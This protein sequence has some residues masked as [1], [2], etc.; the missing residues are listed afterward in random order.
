MEAS[1][2]QDQ[3]ESSMSSVIAVIKSVIGQV[4]ALTPEG[5]QRLLIEGDRLFTG[6]QLTTGAAG[7]VSLQLADGRI[8]DLGR[9]TQWSAAGPETQASPQAAGSEVGGL[10]QAIAAGADPTAELAPTAAGAEATQAAGGGGSSHSFVILET[11][12]GRLE[13]TVGFTTQGFALATETTVESDS[14]DLAEP[15]SEALTGPAA[16]TNTGAVNSAPTFSA[17]ATGLTISAAEDTSFGGTFS[18]Q[19]PDGDSLTFS[20]LDSPSNGTLSLSPNGDWSY[21]PNPNYNGP[22]S[23]QIA[24]SDSRGGVTNLTLNLNLTPVNDAPVAEADSA[25]AVEGGAAIGGQILASDVDQPVGTALTFSTTSPVPGLTF[26]ADGSWSFDPSDAAYDSLAVGQQLVLEIPVSVTDDQGATGTTSLSITLTGSNDAPVAVAS[27]ASS[28]ENAALNASVAPASDIDGSIAAN[29]YALVSGVSQGSLSFNADGSYSFEPGS[30]FDD[31]A[32]GEFREVT[33]SYSATDND[34][35]VSAPAS[36][37]IRVTGSND[38][39]VATATS[40]AAV[41]DGSVLSGQLAAS[42]ADNGA[43]LSFSLNA[44]TPAGFSLDG[45][46][47]AWSFDPSDAAYQA[48]AEGEVQVIALPFTVT[49]EHGAT[50]QSSLTLTLTGSNDAPVASATTAAAVEDGAVISGQLAASDID[51]NATLTFNLIQ[52]APAGF[53]L[54]SATG[55]W[56]FDANDAVYQSLAAGEQLQISVPFTVT[57]EHGATSQSVLNLTVTGTNDAPSVAAALTAA[58]DE[59]DASFSLDLLAGAGDVDNGAVL[60]VSNVSSLPAGVTLLGSTLT[61]DPAHAAF[62]DLAEGEERLITVSYEVVDQH[63]AS[64]AQSISITITGTNDAPVA[65]ATSAAAAEDD[66]MLN[67]QLAASDVDSSLLTFSLNAAT[68]AGFSLDGATGAWSFD[69]SDAAYQALADGEVQV[70]ELPFTVTDEHGATSQSV[71]TLTL[72]GSND[73]PVASATTA[74]AVEDGILNPGPVV[75]ATDGSALVISIVTTDPNQ[76]FSFDWQFSTGDYLPFDDFA[77]IQI[78]GQPVSL[79]SSV[80]G[81]GSGGNSGQ[82]TL[83]HIFATPGTHQIVIGVSDAGDTSVNSALSISNL[84]MDLVTSAT[85]VGA[86]SNLGGTW[87]LT[88][89][90]ASNQ[91][92]TNLLSPDAVTGQLQASDIDHNATLTFS[93]IQTAPAGFSLDSSTGAWTFDPSDAAYQALAAGEIKVIELPFTVTDEHGATSQSVL[94]LTVTGTNDAPSVAAALTAA[95]DEDDASFNLDLLAGANDVDNSAVLGVTN[96]SSLPAGLTLLGSTLNVDPAHAAFQDLAAGEERLITVSYEVV[97]QHGASVAQSISITI[98]GTNDVPSVA[99]ALTAAANEDASS[100][101]LDLLAGAGDVDNGAVLGVSNLNGLVDGLSLSGSTLTVDPAHAAFQNL[102]AGEERLI[103]VTYEVVDQHGASVAQS[104]SITITGTNDAPVASLTSAAAAEDAALING[105]LAASDADTNAVLSFSLNAAAPA[106]FSLDGATG[107]WT[108]DPSDAAYQAL[109]EGEVQVIELPFTVTDEHGATSQSV[110]SLTVTGTNDAPSVAAALTAAADEDDA[111]FSL[112]LLAGANDVD[113]GST[114]GVA[115][116][117]SLPAGVSLLGSTLSVDPAHAAFQDL[118]AGEERQIVVSYE[119]VDGQGGSVA[120]TATIT[121]TGSNDAPSV[122]AALNAAANEDAVSFSLDLLAGANDVDNGAV[123]GVS[124]LYGLVDGLSLSGST[125]TVDPAHAAFQ[126]LAAGEERQIVVSYEVIDGQGGSIAQTATITITGTNDAPVVDVVNSDSSDTLS[127]SDAALSTQGV[128]VFSDID[129]GD[130]PATSYT[131]STISATGI[132]LSAAEQS[133]ISNA[134]S[135][136]ANGNWS[137]SLPSPDYLAAGD[138]VTAVFTVTVT[139]DEGVTATQD[140]TLTI[141]GTNDAPTV[142]SA[143]SAEANEDAAGFDLDLLSG[144]A[145]VDNGDVLSV[146]NVQGLVNGL[147]LNGTTLSVDPAHADFQSLVLNETRDIVISYDVIDGNGGVTPQT[148]T[149]TITGT[150][151]L[152]SIAGDAS[153]A[154]SEDAASP[155]LSDSGSLTIS[156]AD[157]GQASFQTTGITASPGALGSLSITSAGVW[158]YNVA[159]ADVQYLAAGATKVETFTVLSADGSAHDV[160]ITITGTNDAPLISGDASGAVSEDAASPTLSDSGSLTISDADSG[161]ASFQTTGI[162]ASPGALGSLGITSTGIWTYNVANADVQY[163]AAGATKVETFTVLSAEGSAHDVVI[164]ITGTNDAPTVSSALTAAANEDA[165]GFDL[166]LLSGAADVDNGDVLSVSNV[167]GLVNGLSLNGTTLSVDPA[168]ADFQS[169]VAGETRDIVISYDVI[170]GNGGVTPQ[171]ATITITGTNDAPLIQTA[172]TNVNGQ[173]SITKPQGMDNHSIANAIDLDGQFVLGTDPDVANAETVPFVSISSIGNNAFDYYSF[174]VTQAGTTATFDI[175]YGMNQGVSFDPWLNLYDAAGNLIA[176]NDDADIG[177]GGAGSIHQYDSFLTYSFSQPGTYYIAVGR[178]PDTNIPSGGTYQLQVSLPNAITATDL[179]ERIDGSADENTG[180]LNASGS[181]LF[182]DVDLQD[183]HSVSTTLLSSVDS[184]G[185]GAA[186]RGTLTASIGDASTGDSSGR[187]DWNYNVDAAALDNLAAGQV[188]TL[189]YRISIDDSQGGTDFRDVTITLTGT[190][191]APTVSAISRTNS[192]DDASFSLDLLSAANAQDVDPG[193]ALSVTGYS[194]AIDSGIL[195]SGALSL[196]ADGRT[197]TVDPNAFGFL[198]AGE[199]R[200]ITVSYSVFDGTTSVPNTATLTITGTNDVPVA[201]ADSAI[202]NEGASVI[203]NLASNDS[204][205]DDGLD[206]SSIAIID[207]PANGTLTVNANGTVSYQHNGSETTTDSFTYTIKDASGA[208]SNP[209]SVSVDVT[210]INDA[211]VNS[212]PASYIVNE[213]TP[214]KLSG[215][216]VTDADATSGAISVT[217]AVASGTI[218]AANSSGVTVTGSGSGSLVLSGTLAE[219]NAYLAAPATQ[220][221]YLPVA[222]ASGAVTLTMTSNDGGNTGA[223]GTL[224]DSDT[225]TITITP[226]ADAVPGSDVSVVIGS[227]LTNTIS[228]SSGSNLH[229]LSSYTFGNGIT[230]STGGNG[231]FNWSNGNDVGVNG[232]GDNGTTSQ[233]IEGNEAITFNFPY[234]MQYMALKLKNSAD[235]T[236]LVRSALEVGDLPANQTITGTVTSSGGTVSSTNLKVD[237]VLEVLNG[238]TTSSVTLA[239]TVSSGGTWSVSYSG[240]TGTITKATVVSTIDGDLF[241]QGGNTSA[242]VTYSIN[243]DMQSLSIAQDP[244]NS[245]SAGQTNNGFQIEY[246]AVDPSPS[247]LT[248]YSY[249][250]DIYALVQDTV[251]TVESFTGLTLSELP[252][253]SS[254]SVV[255]ADGTYQEIAANAQG[256]YDLSA[257]TSLLSTATTTSGTDKIYLI[258]DSALP[259]GFAPTLTLEVSDGGSSTAKTIIGGSADSTFSGGSGNDYISGGA[260]SD[261]LGGGAGN[262]TLDGGTGSDILI[263][264]EGDDILF[265]STGADSFVW[266]SG[267]S[268]SD[269]LKDFNAAEGDRIDLRDLLQGEEN[270]ADLTQFLRVDIATSTLEISSNGQLNSGGAADLSIKLENGGAPLDLSAY[271]GTSAQIVN[272]LIAGADPLVKT[273]HS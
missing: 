158:T 236:A 111:S 52:T 185:S 168:H 41:E 150:I 66:A 114:L 160:V 165:A 263:G 194:A 65:T 228:F 90:G 6:E 109:A 155:I 68:P 252:A 69:P 82:Q 139:D 219:I 42:D 37:T 235:D 59:D 183:G 179:S 253:G 108:F 71:L 84:P 102:A 258:T 62:Q 182:S 125:L 25:A 118:A 146:S 124:N 237:L 40:A 226:V 4:I 154:V 192:E 164:T 207:G 39:P 204:D 197:L 13:A 198:S 3:G 200:V 261:S 208:T 134:F 186:A 140:V 83:T 143:L 180:S 89:N 61:V 24:V 214:L 98:T 106:G 56:T 92:L 119:V 137:F 269:T 97:D 156:D 112:D 8:L 147:S 209:V 128:I 35:A 220:P 73:A 138:Q 152:P 17:D 167:Q 181:L 46:T 101:S 271:G 95:A 53:S 22:D 74:A 9:E 189:T 75:N 64:V 239:A 58:A 5:A 250:V 23:F 184:L 213:D 1:R 210:P 229:G 85:S 176:Q 199:S 122:T 38:A 188:L 206:L 245:F 211:P 169:L 115:N 254:I 123:L 149:I 170:D 14:E 191:D 248:S 190:N 105:Q 212:L 135:V 145:D 178:F 21:T 26:N 187:I 30:D 270:S 116:V 100:F 201:S 129:S 240:V 76:T 12:A 230:I 177:L 103:S 262:D 49:D 99:A 174:T 87:T 217:L 157:S 33:F 260:G 48:L 233:R 70:I 121:I 18:A 202:V 267:D 113:N 218:S 249:P 222:D 224:S 265:G 173:G 36:V 141:T 94:S 171:T 159:N 266:N 131:G 195:P 11:T 2:Q 161:Q 251:G 232:P 203:I 51:H 144:T 34:G 257:Y 54:N 104:I 223:G 29:G 244:S 241:N 132:A 50:S 126:D 16:G 7:M 20:L 107:E 130:T 57:D 238:G 80:A 264:D 255:R 193:A 196:A 246:I 259:A 272:S 162:T 93:L 77:F 86:A 231:T 136:D 10:Q 44:A 234:G 256:E 216:S 27:T 243:S 47:G 163:L 133:A 32:E 166:D 31:L 110:L 242:N 148:V 45:A 153:G 60:G 19:D 63:G 79:L 225:A 15:A 67:G 43:L 88:S 215:L 142:S 151:D 72:T 91:E 205:A 268:G 247:G 175:D 221:T 28:G 117:S 55:A 227:A 81:V 127:E 78:D 96:V 273:D 172:Y 120:Q